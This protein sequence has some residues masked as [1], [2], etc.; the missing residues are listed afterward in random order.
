MGELLLRAPESI[1]HVHRELGADDAADPELGRGL[2]E[3]DRSPQVVVIGESERGIAECLG[4]RD[5][6]LGFGGAVEEGEDGVAV[7]LGVQRAGR[8]EVRG[9]RPGPPNKYRIHHTCNDP[10]QP[11]DL[12]P[13]TWD[14]DPVTPLPSHPV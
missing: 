2:R 7:E 1:R 12:G 8:S 3:P 4:S 5:E 10:H 9:S 13:G 6:C 11:W 14:L